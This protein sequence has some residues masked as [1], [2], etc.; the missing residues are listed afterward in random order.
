VWD[1]VK[2]T[3]PSDWREGGEGTP[4][5]SREFKGTRDRDRE[6]LYLID[7]GP[8]KKGLSETLRI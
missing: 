2:V 3:S 6:A 8:K 1:A 5:N 7:D 4:R